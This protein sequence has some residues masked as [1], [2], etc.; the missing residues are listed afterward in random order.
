[1]LD[2]HV[3]SVDDEM[4]VL[5]RIDRPT[6]D[7]AAAS[8]QHGAA[9]HLA[10]ASAMLGDVRDPQLVEFGA[11]EPPLDEVIGCRCPLDTPDL[12]RSRK[13]GVTTRHQDAETNS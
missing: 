10:F 9:V 1:L 13:C 8:V 12:D 2:G 6:D 4:R 5:D 7:P 3:E 11:R